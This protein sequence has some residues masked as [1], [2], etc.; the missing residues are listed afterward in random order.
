MN[1]SPAA[2]CVTFTVTQE[3]NFRS[4]RRGIETTEPLSHL[5]LS[6]CLFTHLFLSVFLSPCANLI[7]QQTQGIWQPTVQS[8]AF[9]YSFVPGPFAWEVEA[10]VV[11]RLCSALPVRKRKGGDPRHSTEPRLSPHALFS[12]QLEPHSLG[13]IKACTVRCTLAQSQACECFCEKNP[14]KTRKQ[15]GSFEE[16]SKHAGEFMLLKRLACYIQ[17]KP[18]WPV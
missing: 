13:L 8:V 10:L 3:I 2:Y 11:C 5:S 6:L 4:I 17:T 7:T 14:Q 12:S 15:F 16:M 9:P 18:S 1:W